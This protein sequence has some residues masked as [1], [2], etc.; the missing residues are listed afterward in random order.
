MMCSETPAFA[1]MCEMTRCLCPTLSSASSFVA[2]AN[3]MP[4]IN[5][6]FG[7]CVSVC[8]SEYAVVVFSG[9]FAPNVKSF[10]DYS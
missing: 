10:S 5:L 3:S 9:S 8:V 1:H 6:L 4:H 2:P 7:L